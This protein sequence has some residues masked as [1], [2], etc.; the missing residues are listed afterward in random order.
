M[1]IVSSKAVPT[2]Q[3]EEFD[4]RDN[5]SFDMRHEIVKNCAVALGLHCIE[6]IPPEWKPSDGHVT[7]VEMRAHVLT[8]AQYDDLIVKTREAA[9]R[10]GFQSGA[11]YEAGRIERCVTANWRAITKL[12]E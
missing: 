1:L 2:S 12:A 11:Q 4:A 7:V 8:Q 10:S 5:T 6:H 9:F 3:L